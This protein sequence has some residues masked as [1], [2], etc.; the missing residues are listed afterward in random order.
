MIHEE[1]EKTRIARQLKKTY[2]MRPKDPQRGPVRTLII[3]RKRT[4]APFQN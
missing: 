4:I 3:M 2:L 1:D